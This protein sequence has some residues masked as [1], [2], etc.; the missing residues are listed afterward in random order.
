MRFFARTFGF[1]AGI[2]PASL[3]FADSAT[4]PGSDSGLGGLLLVVA[5]IVLLVVG[6]VCCCASSGSG[7]GGPPSS[8]VN[9]PGKRGSTSGSGCTTVVGVATC[10]NP[11]CTGGSSCGGSSCGGGGCSS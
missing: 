11:S 5:V 10:S 2:F 6:I 7:S 4:T 1:A 8:R 3:A 9:K